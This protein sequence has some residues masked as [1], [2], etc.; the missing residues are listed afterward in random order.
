MKLGITV[1]HAIEGLR[2]IFNIYELEKRGTATNREE[3]RR[4]FDRDYEENYRIDNT[5]REN[6][7]RCFFEVNQ[8]VCYDALTGRIY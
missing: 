7:V 8:I 4:D 2:K 5:K 1:K 6:T 3:Y